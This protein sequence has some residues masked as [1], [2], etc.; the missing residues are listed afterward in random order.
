MDFIISNFNWRLRACFECT[1]WNE[2]LD[3]NSSIDNNLDVINSYIIFCMDSI[4]PTCKKRRFPNTKPWFN[5][6]IYQIYAAKRSC[7]DNPTLSNELERKARSAIRRAKRELKNKTEQEFS[8]MNTKAAYQHLKSMMTEASTNPPKVTSSDPLT[9]ATQLNL[10]YN[11]FDKTDF[12][13]EC[14]RLMSEGQLVAGDVTITETEVRTQLRRVKPSKAAG[15]DGLPAK[16]LNKCAD[17]LA[18]AFLPLF[19]QSVDTGVIPILWKSSTIV[20]VP[21]KPKVKELN[22]FRPVA[23]TPLPMK[24]LEK[25]VLKNL[26]PFVEPHLD[27][28]QFAYRTGRGVEDAIATL[29]HKLLKHIESPGCYARILFADFSSAFNTMQRH[30]LIKKL[31]DLKVPTSIVKWILDFLT[32]RRQRVKIDNTLSPEISSN[33][34]APQGCVLSPFLYITYTNDC[35][36]EKNCTCVKFADDS[37]I[38]GLISDDNTSENDYFEAIDNFAD[39]CSNHHLELNVTKTKEL[40]IDFRPDSGPLT[41]VSIDNDTVEV[42][43]NFKYLGVTLDS[44]LD[45]KLHVQNVQ[46]KGQ[47]RLHV[48]RRLRSF[49]LNSKLLQNLYRSII[50]PILIYCGPI[51]YHQI[52]TTDRN[53]IVKISSTAEKIHGKKNPT[54]SGLVQKATVRKAQAVAENPDH[55]LNCEFEI[56]SS[57]RRYRTMKCK[58]A[59][60]SRSFVPNAIK[61]LNDHMKSCT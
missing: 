20:P 37:A 26:L 33:T 21:K 14:S 57:G 25:I 51:F 17:S 18:P 47:Q 54:L 16:L 58:K 39:W 50:E 5:S 4:M 53:K 29:L 61:A 32:D 28:L 19:Q 6:E 12:S 38:L 40:I 9:L 36:C 27:P 41:P 8:R 23:L 15:P 48:L 2:L 44:K 42:V 11:R 1:E 10:F 60:F 7:L 35:Q 22:N 59:K 46:K 49:H 30:T 55:P 45:F 34:G 31:Q 24:C 52:S 3:P 56:L 13:N 43:D